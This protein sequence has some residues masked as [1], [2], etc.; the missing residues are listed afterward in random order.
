MNEDDY[1]EA[2]QLLDTNGFQAS[3]LVDATSRLLKQFKRFQCALINLHLILLVEGWHTE[4]P[5]DCR[6]LWLWLGSSEEDYALWVERKL[7][8]EEYYDRCDLRA[9]GHIWLEQN[10]S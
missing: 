6:R 9:P 1:L 7:S 5:S 4:S 10:Y 8:D 3:N 2:K